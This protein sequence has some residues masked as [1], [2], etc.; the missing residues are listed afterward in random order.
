MLNVVE[1]LYQKYAFAFA[2]RD[3]Y[4]SLIDGVLSQEFLSGDNDYYKRLLIEEIIRKYIQE[5]ISKD[6]YKIVHNYINME[7]ESLTKEHYLEFLMSLSALLRRGNIYVSEIL[8]QKLLEDNP[9]L[10]DICGNIVKANKYYFQTG[11]LKE[12][13]SDD[14]SL[15]LLYGYCDLMEL[16]FTPNENTNIY[17]DMILPP[18]SNKE[19]E[20]ATLS[21]AK[22]GDAKALENVVCRYLKMV[23]KEANWYKNNFNT[24]DDLVDQGVIGIIYAVKSYDFSRGIS[25]STYVKPWIRQIIL[26]YLERNSGCIRVSDEYRS[27]YRRY[28]KAAEVLLQELG[29]EPRLDEIALSINVDLNKLVNIINLMDLRICLDMP[30]KTDEIEES[31]GNLIPDDS[32]DIAIATEIKANEMLLRDGILKDILTPKEYQVVL[33]RFGFIN[34]NPLVRP[35]IAEIMNITHQRVSQLENSALEKIMKSKLFDQYIQSYDDY[36]EKLA[37]LALRRK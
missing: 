31:I 9:K 6:N 25:F 35:L 15:K 13:V 11:Q 14:F 29:R 1:K 16:D 17:S 37:I 4:L 5:N 18:F 22:I 24:F 32:T 36:Q 8:A 21:K 23:Y 19:Q 28:K 7:G 27:L 12:L 33:L 2:S 34:N 20:Y 3:T 10:I 26:R 30:I